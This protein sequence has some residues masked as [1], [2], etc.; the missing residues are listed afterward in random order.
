MSERQLLVL[1]SL[2]NLPPGG[3]TYTIAL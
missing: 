1:R 2:L 3:N